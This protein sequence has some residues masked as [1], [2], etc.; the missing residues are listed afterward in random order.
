MNKHERRQLK[1]KAALDLLKQQRKRA[2][3]LAHANASAARS[4]DCADDEGE[5]EGERD[6]KKNKKKNNN[7]DDEEEKDEAAS[8]SSDVDS[9]LEALAAEQRMDD[10]HHWYYFR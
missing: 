9:A 2:F 3:V 7:A 1:K 4:A 10:L 8:G 5:R 6:N